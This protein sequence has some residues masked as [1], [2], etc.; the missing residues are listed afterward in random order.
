MK[1]S[2]LS[3]R[4][5]RVVDKEGISRS[6]EAIHQ[7]VI[8]KASRKRVYEALTDVK[9]FDRVVQ[10]S[11]ARMSLG[12]KPTEISREVGGAFSLFG[13]HIQGRNIE[14]IRDERLV[15]AW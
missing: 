3:L 1:G 9:Q 11:Q 13:G 7:E 6:A 5:S 10:L 2:S 14:L 8:F 15:Q 12:V 4:S